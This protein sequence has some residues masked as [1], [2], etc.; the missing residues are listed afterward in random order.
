MAGDHGRDGEGEQP[1]EEGDEETDLADVSLLTVAG[2]LASDSSVLANSLQRLL[3]EVD[4]S[5]EA[6]SAW[7]SFTR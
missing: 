1:V 7:S 6:I 5:A 2:L 4:L 3:S